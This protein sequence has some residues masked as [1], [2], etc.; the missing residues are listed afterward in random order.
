[1]TRAP[2]LETI[3]APSL[4]SSAYVE[5]SQF[6]A[7]KSRIFAREWMVAARSEEI[8]AGGRRVVDVAGESI[9]LLRAPDGQ[10]HAHHNVCR[11]RG[12]RLCEP[13]ADRKP[14]RP[15]IAE[16][17][18]GGF[19]RC[20]YHGWVYDAAGAL[21]ATPHVDPSGTFDRSGLSLYPVGLAEWGGFVFLCLTPQDAI[22][23]EAQIGEIAARLAN[24]P[25][26][27]LRIGCRIAYEV[28]AN[29]KIICE[30]YNECYH[31]G[32]MHPEL[33][34]LVPAFRQGGADGLDWRSGIP[35]RDG[36]VTFTWTGRTDR[37]SFPGLDENERTRH[38]GEL[39]YPNLFLSLAADHVAAFILRPKGPASTLV[40]CL[41]LFAAD[42]IAREGFDHAD[43][44][45]FWDVVNQQDWAI[46]ERVQRGMSSSAH[47]QGFYAPMED[48]NL[49]MRRYLL[50]R[51][52]RA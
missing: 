3:L 4:P 34:A 27:D 49:D 52:S 32:P 30:N 50:E 47:V 37:A 45:T 13:E 39:L 6:A 14:G 41:F 12:A 36:A 25:L 21:V 17:V 2:S 19:V 51:M 28:D 5:P 10:L 46:C 1:M 20:P 16:A 23:L 8:A 22:T 35:H 15:V 44:S 7:E 38:K 29:W 33:C 48:A 18:A 40:E 43:A 31:C 11:H 26:A 9:L 42:E 24:Y